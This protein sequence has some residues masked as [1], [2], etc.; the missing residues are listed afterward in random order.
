MLRVKQSRLLL[1][2]FLV[3]NIATFQTFNNK[4]LHNNKHLYFKVEN[5][6]FRYFERNRRSAEAQQ[7]QLMKRKIRIED[8]D[9][10]QHQS[11]NSKN[12]KREIISADPDDDGKDIISLIF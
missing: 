3:F 7:Q 6:W 8:V 9:D 2:K 10:H 1:F 5:S 4:H 11:A 12:K